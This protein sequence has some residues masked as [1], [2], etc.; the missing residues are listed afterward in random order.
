MVV[1]VVEVGTKK[2]LVL[3]YK[4]AIFRGTTG[5]T[6]YNAVIGD[7]VPLIRREDFTHGRIFAGMVVFGSGEVEYAGRIV[8]PVNI[9]HMFCYGKGGFY[10]DKDFDGEGSAVIAEVDYRRDVVGNPS[11][12]RNL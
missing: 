2:I 7:Q 12:M 4:T 5:T 11:G 1:M 3:V 10:G 9:A 8:V 6:V